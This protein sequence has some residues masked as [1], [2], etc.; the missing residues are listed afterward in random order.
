M[1]QTYFFIFLPSFNIPFVL[2]WSDCSYVIFYFLSQ[3]VM[4]GNGDRT[5]HKQRRQQDDSIG[6]WREITSMY[7]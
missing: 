3:L 6:F 2:V 5:N 7:K 1:L 4:Q